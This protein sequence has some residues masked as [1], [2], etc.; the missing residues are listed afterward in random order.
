MSYVITALY[1]LITEYDCCADVITRTIP[2]KAQREAGF[3][4]PGLEGIDYVSSDNEDD[5]AAA[6]INTI[7]PMHSSDSSDDDD[8]DDG[9]V[10][11]PDDDRHEYSD[12]SSDNEGLEAAATTEFE[13]YYNLP[14]GDGNTNSVSMSSAGIKGFGAAAEVQSPH[15]SHFCFTFHHRDLSNLRTRMTPMESAPHQQRMCCAATTNTATTPSTMLPPPC[16]PQER[17]RERDQQF[18]P[19]HRRKL[20]LHVQHR[21]PPPP[22]LRLRMQIGAAKIKDSTRIMVNSIQSDVPGGPWVALYRR[23]VNFN[24]VT[25]AFYDMVFSHRT[26][27]NPDDEDEETFWDL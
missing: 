7:S 13:L 3:D 9:N 10:V 24:G 23:R 8:D 5:G 20:S 22:C 17:E 21:S 15:P 2:E 27:D 14:A 4:P 6:D 19:P 1:L 25:H 16:L 12:A 18:P 11:D 26:E